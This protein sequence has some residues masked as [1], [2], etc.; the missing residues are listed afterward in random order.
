MNGDGHVQQTA[1]QQY[2]TNNPSYQLGSLIEG[3][4]VG[5]HYPDDATNQS[6]V[7]VEYDVDPTS[8]FGMTRLYRVPRGDIS[9]GID[10]RDDSILRAADATVGSGA[11][12]PD[13]TPSGGAQE[14]ATPRYQ[15]TGD[16][17]LVG[18]IN[19]NVYRPVILGVLTHLYARNSSGQPLKDVKGNVIAG[20]DKR[21]RVRR[22]RHRGTEMVMD[23]QGNVTVNFAKTPDQNGRD[24]NDQKALR[25]NIGDFEIRIDNS[26]SPTTCEFKVKDGNTILKFTKDGFEVG[27]T[28]LEPMVLGNKLETLLN[29]VLDDLSSHQHIGN[30][31]APTPRVDGGAGATSLKAQVAPTKSD[32]AKVTK[33]KP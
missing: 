26:S 21:K 19:N 1:L 14:A 5:V 30:L 32:W 18:F 28:G 22:T 16:R 27:A 12:K 33:A 3:V 11:F 20:K 6:K 2:L 23:E 25:L 24:T 10:D 15:T 9:G 13:T 31:G 29:A 7:C 17:V 4:V 8:V